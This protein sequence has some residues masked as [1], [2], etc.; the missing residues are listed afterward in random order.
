MKFKI[1]YNQPS[2]TIVKELEIEVKS[3][4][5][6]PDGQMVDLKCLY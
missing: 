2:T 5:I 3:D 1:Q 4:L 6:L